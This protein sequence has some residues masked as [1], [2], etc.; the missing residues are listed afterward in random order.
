MTAPDVRSFADRLDDAIARKSSCLV[1]G[2]DP[3][4]DRLPPEVHGRVR[5]AAGTPGWTA[6]VALAFGTFLGEVIEQIADL[7]V[8]V[9]PNTAYFERLGAVGWDVLRR[10]AEIAQRAGLL[11]IVDAKR[12]D[13]GHTAEAYAD[14]LLGETPDTLGPVSDAVTLHPYTGRDGITPWLERVTAGGKGLFVLVRTSNPGASDLQEI[15]CGGRPFYERVAERVGE[16]GRTAIGKRGLG[17]VG[18][19]VG[20][21]A[22]AAAE[23]IRAL[24]P[25]RFFLA[26]GFG[27]QGAGAAE[28]APLFLAGGRGV[29]VNASRSIL[30]PKRELGESWSEAV[31]RAALEARDALES[32]R[33]RA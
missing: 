16:W 13:I 20:A 28:L 14:A 30:Y 9:K 7:A 6:H 10:V 1:V 2:L 18:A 31:R 17:S 22:P 12:G 24:L 33:G 21:T 25:D 15:D 11:V 19:V 32:V 27:A 5:A 4:A 29:V 8:A 3:V 26:P 23:R